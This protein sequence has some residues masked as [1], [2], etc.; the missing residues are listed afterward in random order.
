[1]RFS[2]ITDSGQKLSFL[3]SCVGA[4]LTELW[5]KEVRVAYKATGDRATRVEAHT[6]AQVVEN[7]KTTL[8]KLVSRDRAIIDLLRIE[9]GSRGFMD[10]LADIE[11]QTHLCH[12]WQQLTGKDLK[13][14]SL[15][16][17]L[18]DRTLAEKAHAE[19]YS[20][21]QIIQAA[22]NRESSRA[23]AEAIRNRPTGNVNWLEDE[24]VQ[25]RGGSLEARMNHL[26]VE[27][28]EVM[29]LKQI[30]KYSG[31]HKGEGEK[32]QCPKCTYERHKPG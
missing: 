13:R 24:E 3:R 23:N 15:L 19:E 11:D 9:Q 20:L 25:Y 30:G 22:V 4:E 1:M 28:E 21:T 8:L 6:Y 27:M 7:T 31:R 26:Q 2:G 14:I 29:K 16:G 18:K 32:E 10:F 12:S 5:D 17:G